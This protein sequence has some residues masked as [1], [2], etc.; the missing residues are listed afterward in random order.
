[1]R[2]SEE[3]SKHFGDDGSP[4]LRYLQFRKTIGGGDVADPGPEF[5][6]PGSRVKEMPG[7]ASASK[8]SSFLTQK[9]VYKLSEL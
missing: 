9:I 1:M 4:I 6:H 2:D 5:C 3:K 7:S 8:N